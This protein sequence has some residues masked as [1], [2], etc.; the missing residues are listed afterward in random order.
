M[1]LLLDSHI[2]LALLDEGA[3]KLASEMKDAINAALPDVF[4][5]TV[6]L[7]EVKIKF[8]AVRISKRMPNSRLKIA[9]YRAVARSR[10]S[11]GRSADA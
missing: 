1:K 4:L 10:R 6:S 8:Q 7:W 3:V 9:A 5:S 2:F 11:G